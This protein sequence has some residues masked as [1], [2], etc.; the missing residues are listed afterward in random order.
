[1]VMPKLLIRFC[2]WFIAGLLPTIA[3]VRKNEV[4]DIALAKIKKL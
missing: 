3:A 1:M 2:C 4:K